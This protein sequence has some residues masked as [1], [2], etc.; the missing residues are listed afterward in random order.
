MIREIVK[1]KGNKYVLNLPDEMVGKTIEVVATEVEE[2]KP[3]IL[4]KKSFEQLNKE[5]EGLTINLSNFKFNRNEA[6]DYD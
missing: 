5:L 2:E 3:L 4:A 6:N 1:P